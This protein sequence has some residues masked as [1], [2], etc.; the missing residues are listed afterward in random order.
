MRYT[1]FNREAK[2]IKLELFMRVLVALESGG[3]KYRLRS[4]D[5]YAWSSH[6]LRLQD[7]EIN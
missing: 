3:V 2:N 5:D 7:T 4:K 6:V 1:V